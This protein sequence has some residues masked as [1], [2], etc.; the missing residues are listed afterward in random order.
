MPAANSVGGYSRPADFCP[1]A[2]AV[3]YLDT[4]KADRA[5]ERGYLGQ[6]VTVAVIDSPVRGSDPDLA[7]RIAP[8]YDAVAN[9]ARRNGFTE[10]IP[11][12][13]SDAHGTAVAAIIGAAAGGGLRHGVA[14]LV[15]LL[16]INWEETGHVSALS[17][18]VNQNSVILN[19][20]EY[21]I[22]RAPDFIN[23]SYSSSGR[24]LSLSTGSFMGRT[25]DIDFSSLIGDPASTSHLTP[26]SL[27]LAATVSAQM[28]GAD[29]VQVF[30]AGNQGFNSETGIVRG[31]VCNG[32][33]GCSSDPN[34]SISTARLFAE[35]SFSRPLL[36]ANPTSLD[37]STGSLS[38]FDFH[39]NA[40]S[41]ESLLPYFEP[42]LTANWLVAVATDQNDVIASF[43]N[44]CG[45]ARFWC[46]SAP[47]VGVYDED[48]NGVGI[49]VSGTSY[50]APHATGALAVLKSRFP[51]MPNAVVKALLLFTADDLGE[52]GLDEVY[53]HGRINLER[54]VT[55]QGQI[56]LAEE[57]LQGRY[58]LT[59]PNPVD[60]SFVW[61]PAEKG[62]RLPGYGGDGDPINAGE[63]YRR[64]YFGQGVTVAVVDTGVFGGH[65]EFAGRVER[66]RN[67]V[68]AEADRAADLSCVGSE[69]AGDRDSDGHGTHVAGIIG[70]ELNG[71]LMNGVAPSVRIVPVAFLRSDDQ[72]NIT[73]T[74]TLTVSPLAALRYALDS[75]ARFINNSWGSVNRLTTMLGGT[76]YMA[77]LPFFNVSDSQL[78]MGSR[79]ADL[80][81]GEDAVMVWAAGNSGWN[82]E[83]GVLRMCAGLYD[84][85][86]SCTGNR[87]GV[88][89]DDFLA[90]VTIFDDSGAE[91]TWKDEL[92]ENIPGILSRLPHFERSL[93]D[94]WLAVVA[95]DNG[96]RIA[97]FS[98]GCGVA[99]HW[100]LAAPGV[101]VHST[102]PNETSSRVSVV[103]RCPATTGPDCN[104]V[105]MTLSGTSMAAPHVT[106]ALAVLASRF[107]GIPNEVL[108]AILLNSATDLGAAGVDEVYGHGMLNLEDAITMQ[109]EIR[110]AGE[111]SDQVVRVTTAMRNT[112]M[113]NPRRTARLSGSFAHLPASLADHRIAYSFMDG[114]YFDVPFKSMLEQKE[115]RASSS[116][117]AALYMLERTVEHSPSPSYGLS[118]RVGRDGDVKN[119]A[120]QIG[121]LNIRHEPQ[122]EVGPGS[123]QF[124][125]PLFGLGSTELSW[126]AAGAGLSPFVAFGESGSYRQ[127]GVRWSGKAGG[128]DLAAAL[129]QIEE[130][131]AL[132][133]SS[134]GEG[135]LA[136]SGSG[137]SSQG[138]IA[139]SRGL[140]AGWTGHA[141]YQWLNSEDVQGS[142]LIE[143]LSDIR[144]SSWQFEAEGG[145]PLIPGSHV[146]MV[147]GRDRAMSGVMV[148]RSSRA[149]DPRMVES[150]QYELNTG[151][152][153]ERLTS[154]IDSP[155]ELFAAAGVVLPLGK[156]AQMAMGL[157]LRELA[158]GRGHAELSLAWQL[159]L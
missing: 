17:I 34:F 158:S 126:S 25:I 61:D 84:E 37:L 87:I 93:I 24:F 138:G 118:A 152:E 141:R 86:G 131:D 125:G 62:G 33:P 67:F 76:T 116:Q 47:G 102:F 15:S 68:C 57:S 97:S 113:D 112:V 55:A 60:P 137:S 23:N 38:E 66:G 9:E 49:T 107:P 101:A 151:F 96:N 4:I 135:Q 128:F 90:S 155:G 106:G 81:D 124:G 5:Y 145:A 127:L 59:A 142:S 21:A 3:C 54:A 82:S 71:E 29:V 120:L 156:E 95:A 83:T 79:F 123:G 8:L 130:R 122:Q 108:K 19:A 35:A 109:G 28:Q 36:M 50:A 104:N 52:P 63:A 20:M 89:L 32:M 14:P 117:L 13:D 133:G 10:E 27:I 46:V 78:S 22:G 115:E 154:V 110:L 80:M 150:L 7:G 48:E 119:L 40:P 159:D 16:P 75:D 51:E 45:V 139:A 129:S 30:S 85:Y 73:L 39:Q 143:S 2:I 11:P 157:E 77:N 42:S 147:L 58:T 69:A 1:P 111:T 105:T 44:G 72:R 136:L 64:G 91:V 140:G 103:N 114:Y 94:N 121:G 18:Q 146:R 153:T 65:D 6:G 41:F 134:F 56:D 43:S 12:P 70:A 148:A 98:N 88:G 74:L 132:L 53:G 31:R 149:T 100:C 92:A 26:S 144:Q 99:R